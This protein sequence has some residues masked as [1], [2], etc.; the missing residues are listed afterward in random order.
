MSWDS[1]L[2]PTLSGYWFLTHY[3]GTKYKADTYSGYKL[4]FHS[5]VCGTVFFV[6]CYLLLSLFPQTKTT[7]NWLEEHLPGSNPAAVGLTLLA[8]FGLPPIFN[9]IRGEGGKK[10][11]QNKY[12]KAQ[13][14]HIGRLIQDSSEKGKPILITLTSR[15]IYVGVPLSSA[16]LHRNPNAELAI[17]PY[18]SGFR[19][20]K[21]HELVF[22]TD[23]TDIVL[24]SIEGGKDRIEGLDVTDFRVVIPVSEI[25]SVRMFDF[26]VYRRFQDDA[27]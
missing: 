20:K 18:A 21:T 17:I 4:L 22:N 19:D 1:L 6:A 24:S 12:S 7:I 27:T 14:H 15:K 25:V 9:C 3:V 26:C 16:Y 8:G 13:N 2:A 11:A 10:K 23:Y 5:A